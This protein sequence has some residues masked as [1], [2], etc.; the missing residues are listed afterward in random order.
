MNSYA[1]ECVTA[2]D[3][4]PFLTRVRR[5]GEKNRR[6]KRNLLVHIV[7]VFLSHGGAGAVQ[8]WGSRGSPDESYESFICI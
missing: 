7:L 3:T 2:A 4:N 8:H 1:Y 5:G 6:K